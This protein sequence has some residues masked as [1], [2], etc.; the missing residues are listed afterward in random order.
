[1]YVTESRTYTTVDVRRVTSMFA[2][3][4][5][6]ML[7][8]SAVSGWSRQRIAD[9]V[10][11]VSMFV[12]RGFA[13]SIHV[14]LYDAT[15]REIKAKRYTPTVGFG[16]LSAGRPGDAVWPRTL[17]GWVEL[18][19]ATSSAF[20]ELSPEQRQRFLQSLPGNWGT[21]NLDIRHLALVSANDRR[22]SSNQL[23]FE[24]TSYGR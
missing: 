9:E 23:A 22:Y 19:V 14:M 4:L 20:G 2:A 5:D 12:D 16:G 21:S 10:E 3:D 17:G 15:G 11:A 7:E 6:M 13:E 1:M 24:R 18:V 8:T